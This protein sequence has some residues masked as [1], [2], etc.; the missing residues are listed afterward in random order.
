M[1]K[2][3][4]SC[5]QLCHCHNS[6]YYAVITSA[7]G[8]K[9]GEIAST[10]RIKDVLLGDNECLCVCF[11]LCVHFIRIFAP[12]ASVR[13]VGENMAILINKT[14]VSGIPDFIH[15]ARIFL[16]R[17]SNMLG[18]CYAASRLCYTL[19]HPLR[20][21]C[22]AIIFLKPFHQLPTHFLMF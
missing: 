19:P 8:A 10:T 18:S 6:K 11:E 5:F 12:I 2:D 22:V 14:R 9:Y 17:C 21:L 4:V 15:F 16:T 3:L 1:E 7:H 20:R 13:G